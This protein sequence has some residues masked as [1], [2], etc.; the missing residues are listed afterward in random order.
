MNQFHVQTFAG[1]DRV[2]VQIIGEVDMACVDLLAQALGAALGTGRLVVADCS[3]ITFLDST[4]LRALLEARDLA[5]K[6]HAGFRLSS[7]SAAVE[8]V[9]ELSG[10]ASLFDI[11]IDTAPRNGVPVRRAPAGVEA[12]AAAARLGQPSTDPRSA[13]RYPARGWPRD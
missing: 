2:T 13:H 5:H 3:K 1:A 12:E 10:T 4:G 9:L 11:D 8:R 7:V 6:G